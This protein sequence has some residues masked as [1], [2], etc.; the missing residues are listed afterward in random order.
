[1]IKELVICIIIV[2]LIF[3]GNAITQGY[4]NE[5]VN[6]TTQSLNELKEELVK[7]EVNLE[8]SKKKIEETYGDWKNRYKKLAYYVEHDELEKVD[9]QLTGVKSY[10]EMEEFSETVPE[11]DK[12]IFILEHINNKNIVNLK[13]IF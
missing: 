5:S 7:E 3:V 4:L 11:L 13:N 2:V 9:T 1:M 6:I 12:A 8:I 10:I